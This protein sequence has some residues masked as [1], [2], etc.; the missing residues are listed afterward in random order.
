MHRVA[1]L[2]INN[3]I[4][5]PVPLDGG[6]TLKLSRHNFNGK[7]CFPAVGGTAFVPPMTCMLVGIIIDVQPVAQVISQM[8]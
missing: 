1:H 6:Q 5:Q 7:V 2:L 4:Y 8:S 3:L